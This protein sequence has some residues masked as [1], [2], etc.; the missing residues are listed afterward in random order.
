MPFVILVIAVFLLAAGING[1]WPMLQNLV[2]NDV[3][4][5]GAQPGFAAWFF[6]I[7]TLGIIGYYDKLTGLTRLFLVLI[8]L[9][10]FLTNRGFFAN[11]QNAFLNKG[12]AQ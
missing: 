6:V 12:N 3:K 10:I 4:P 8:F 11:L 9:V 7:V 2:V 1:K 5:N